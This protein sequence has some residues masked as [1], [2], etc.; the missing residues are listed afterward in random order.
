MLG[1]L[2]ACIFD[3]L[4]HQHRIG[5]L[6]HCLQAVFDHILRQDGRG[7]R[8]IAGRV[9]RLVGDFIHELCAHVFKLVFQFDLLGDRY[10]VIGDQR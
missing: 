6:F 1:D 5:A 8:T 2:F 4:T 9:I 10:A 3:A 7:R